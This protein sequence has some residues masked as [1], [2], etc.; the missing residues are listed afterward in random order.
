M[1]SGLPYSVEMN[2]RLKASSTVFGLV[3][4]AFAGVSVSAQVHVGEYAP[5]D[6][7]R[8]GQLFSTRCTTCHGDAGDQVPGVSV[9]SGRFRRVS[10]DEDLA[11]LIKSGIP[12]TAMPQGNYSAAELTG[13][14]AYLRSVSADRSWTTASTT[15]A[16]GD[17]QKGHALFHGKAECVTCHRVSGVGGFRGPNLSDIGAIRSDQS[18]RQSLL[19]PS[20]EIIPLNQEIRAV[21]RTGQTITGRRMNEDTYS[22]QLVLDEQGRLVSLMKADLR[23]MAAVKTSPMPSY[24][25]RLKTDELADILAYLHSLKTVD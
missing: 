1:P 14:V 15:I 2:A 20:A 23:Q 3:L 8:G 4:C 18:L 22:L 24:K 25:D 10:S 11:A 16:P 5:A 6:I 13:L 12:G 9:L 21:T 19:D 7:Q 17:A